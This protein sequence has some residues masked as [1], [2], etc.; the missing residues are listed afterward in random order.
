MTATQF[1]GAFNDNVFKQLVLLLCID[2]ALGNPEHDKQGTAQVLFAA[3]FIL[4]S[5][6]AGFLSDRY[7]KRSIVVICKLAEIGI[8]LLGMA[9]F[10]V[11]GLAAPFAVLFLMGTHSAFFG[12]PK[13]G[14]LPELFH[15]RDLPQVNGVILM[16]TFLAVIL[17]FPTAGKLKMIFDGHLWMAS[18]ACV[19]LAVAGTLVSLIIRKCPAV[20][21]DLTFGP[22]SLFVHPQTWSAMR[23]Q[24]GLMAALIAYSV[25]WLAGGV[26]YP[27]VINFV[28]KNQFGLDDLRTGL[29]ASCTGIG[30][31]IGCIV[32]GIL[33]KHQFRANLVRAG[34]IGMLAVLMLLAIPG[35][36][37]E[38]HEI[39]AKAA[40]VYTS[41]ST[42]TISSAGET[43][44]VSFHP[45]WAGLMG[46]KL[47]LGL[48][49]VSAGLFSVPIQV[50]LQARAPHDQ[51]G[52]II[53]VMNLFNWIGIAAAGMYYTA[54][55]TA[56]ASLQAPNIVFAAAGVSIIPLLI[57]YRP[58][59]ESLK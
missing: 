33:S 34:M 6:F 10:L 27:N 49:G 3:P 50:Y 20:Q 32:A 31:V 45:V 36:G 38:E 44:L 11:G 59:D 29:L 12:P 19:G 53:G 41:G 58:K 26:V 52:R 46:S 4:F 7:S 16:T 2:V 18:T 21:P 25:F 55:S 13:Y 8:A 43:V 57:F 42:S 48:L 14:I 9:S 5:G 30:I 37:L 56:T 1:L 47:L 40:K 54:A 35:A 28:G 22:A 15:E 51:K 24:P 39:S 23:R 17:A